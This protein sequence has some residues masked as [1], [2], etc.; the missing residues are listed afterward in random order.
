MYMHICIHAYTYAYMHVYICVHI[1]THILHRRVE[2]LY[3][4]FKVTEMFAPLAS[5]CS[6]YAHA[7]MIVCM[8]M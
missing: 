2:A 3:Q 8:M 4:T 5:A 7:C 6:A 1:H